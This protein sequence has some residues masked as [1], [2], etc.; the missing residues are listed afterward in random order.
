MLHA[1]SNVD[2]E[3]NANKKQLMIVSN[4][5]GSRRKE[6]NHC[7]SSKRRFFRMFKMQI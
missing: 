5:V 1:S 2:F 6:S 7:A 4:S 3:A